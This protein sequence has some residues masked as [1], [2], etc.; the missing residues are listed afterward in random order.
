MSL[1]VVL[2]RSHKGGATWEGRAR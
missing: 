2:L 1:S